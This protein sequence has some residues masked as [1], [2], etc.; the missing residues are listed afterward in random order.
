LIAAKP[1]QKVTLSAEGSKDADGD[2]VDASWFVYP[3]AGTFKGAI[4]LR[5]LQGTTTA[6]VAPPVE[7]PATIHVILRVQD[8]G[9]PPLVSYRRAVVTV[10]PR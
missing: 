6:F 7:S 5:R 1:A 8:K 10:N 4:N 9:A 3:E 2:A